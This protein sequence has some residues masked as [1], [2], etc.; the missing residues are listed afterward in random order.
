VISYTKSRRRRICI[1]TAI[2]WMPLAL[3]FEMSEAPMPEIVSY[4]EVDKMLR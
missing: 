1:L 4:D 2:V 3:S